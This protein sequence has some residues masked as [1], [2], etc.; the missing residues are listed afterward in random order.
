MEAE[1]VK[2]Q[3]KFSQTLNFVLILPTNAPG[4]LLA[5]TPWQ[6]V[7]LADMLCVAELG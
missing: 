1:L 7:P 3:T 4:L 2:P 6:R 5:H